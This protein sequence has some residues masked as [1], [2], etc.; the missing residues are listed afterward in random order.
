MLS[1]LKTGKFR[2]WNAFVIC[3]GKRSLIITSH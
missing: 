2:I 1:K 3:V